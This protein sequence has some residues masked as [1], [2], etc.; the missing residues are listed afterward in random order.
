MFV[1]MS[2]ISVPS[3]RD[4]DPSDQRTMRELVSFFCM[5]VSKEAYVTRAW[6]LPSRHSRLGPISNEWYW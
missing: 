1:L 5:A 2:K 3:C 6:Y 4:M